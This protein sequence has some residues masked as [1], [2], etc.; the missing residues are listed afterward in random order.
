MKEKIIL[1]IGVYLGITIPGN[2]TH[3]L[4]R[5]RDEYNNNLS[6]SNNPLPLPHSGSE[7]VSEEQLANY[8]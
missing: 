2:T 4:V 5:V 6:R 3:Q 1:P 7:Y 8:T